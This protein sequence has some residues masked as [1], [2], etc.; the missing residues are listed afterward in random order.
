MEQHFFNHHWSSR[1]KINS[2]VEWSCRL[3]ING[4]RRFSGHLE[5]FRHA[6]LHVA[7]LI[8]TSR[9]GEEDSDSTSGGF[10]SGY[11]CVSSEE[12]ES[13]LSSVS[14]RETEDSDNNNNEDSKCNNIETVTIS[15]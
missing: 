15:P 10:S 6:E 14:E 3:C 5:A 7:G 1:K 2:C 11:D 13:D 4:G 12:G 8:V 9:G